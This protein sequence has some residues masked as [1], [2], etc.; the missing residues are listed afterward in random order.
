M[1]GDRVEKLRKYFE[2][3]NVEEKYGISFQEFARRVQIGTWEAVLA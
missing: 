2:H 3:F 1:T